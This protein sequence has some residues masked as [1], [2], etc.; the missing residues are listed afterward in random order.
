MAGF[1]AVTMPTE[2]STWFKQAS[3]FAL[4][5]TIARS[6]SVL[7]AFSRITIELNNA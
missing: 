4:S 3:G 1:S 7:A 5:P 6:L 2:F